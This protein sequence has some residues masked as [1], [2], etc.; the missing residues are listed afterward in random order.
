MQPKPRIS[1]FSASN[2]EKED[3]IC[4]GPFPPKLEHGSISKKRYLHSIFACFAP[5]LHCSG[6]NGFQ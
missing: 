1:A 2:I 3:R 4:A 6:L 5:K